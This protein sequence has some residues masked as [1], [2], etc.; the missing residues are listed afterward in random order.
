MGATRHHA[1]ARG[2]VPNVTYSSLDRSLFVGRQAELEQL[3]AAF[4]AAVA[5]DGVLVAMPG[6]PGIGKTTLCQ[7]FMREVA[8]LGGR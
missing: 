6:E 4:Q 2:F 7:Q 3:R 8:D 5:G 1:A